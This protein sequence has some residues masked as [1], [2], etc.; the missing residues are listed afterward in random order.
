ML[1]GFGLGLE[2]YIVHF[3]TII[4][5][6]QHYNATEDVECLLAVDCCC[7]LCDLVYMLVFH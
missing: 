3:I 5:Y 1:K 4:I 6:M 2:I 7:S